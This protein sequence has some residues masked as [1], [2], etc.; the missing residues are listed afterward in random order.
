MVEKYF[1]EIGKIE[2]EKRDARIT[3]DQGKLIEELKDAEFPRD[4][5]LNA[6]NTVASKYFRRKD[7]PNIEKETKLEQLTGRVSNKITQWGYEQGHLDKNSLDDFANEIKALTTRQYGSFN[8][9]VWFNLGLDSY[10]LKQFGEETFYVENGKVKATD[11][12]HEHPQSAACFILSPEDSIKDMIHVGAT[13]SA[14]I[15]KGGSGIGG[16]WS[17][18]RSAGEPVSGGGYASGAIR[19]MD[20]QD[21]SGRVIKSGGKTRRAATMQSIGVW[22][23]DV[24]EVLKHKYKEEQ[25]AKILIESGSPS[26]WESHTIQDLRA[27]NVNISIRIDDEFWKAYENNSNY[28]IKRVK[29]GKIVREVPARDLLEQ[30]AF[31]THQCGDPGIQNHTLINDWNTCKSSGNIWASNPC[32][33][34]M[35]LNGSACNLASHNLMKYR[36]RDG[37]FDLEAFDKATDL[38]ITSQDILVSKSSYPTE[39]IAWNSHIFRPLGL[40]YANLGAY[41]MSLGIP[42]DSE[43]GR[44]FAAAITANMTAE[45]YLQSTKLAEQLGPFQ[46]FSKNKE[47]MMEVISMHQKATKKMPSVNGLEELVM[48][49]NKKWEEVIDRGNKYGFRNAQVTL[50]APTG[51][52]GFMMD[53]DTTGCEPVYATKASKEL[54]GG[55]YMKIVNKTIPLALEKL[56][57]TPE[58]IDKIIKYVEINE[59]VEGAPELKEEHLP[60]FDCA[61]SSGNGT[62]FIQPI[63]H[64]KML[65]AIQP[66]LSGAI[67][68]TINCP[69]STS[70]EEIMEM[71][72][73]SRKYGVKAAAIYRDGSKA[74]QPLTSKK[75]KNIEILLGRGKREPL[76][77]LRKGITQKA[78]VGGT[79]LFLRTGEYDSGRLGEL[80]IES[81]ER[82]SEVNRLL[83]ELAIQFSEKLQYGVPLNEALEIFSKAG[84]SQISG[85][86]N[87]P[88]IK[89]ARGIEGFIYDWI[90]AHYLGNI[91]SVSKNDP[92]LRPF[93]WELRVYQQV[94]KLHL[95]PSV[96]GM[97]F[98][99]GAPTLEE[100]IK[101]ISGTNYW[102]DKE[103]KLDT[104]KTIEKIKK[105]RK[106]KSENIQEEI[107][108]GRM[109]GKTCNVCGSILIT[110]GTCSK[111]PV[112]KISSGGCGA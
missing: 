73:Q 30:I 111:C 60:V 32:S 109:T 101:K 40:G 53:C 28:K 70:V 69:N 54:A 6:S 83:N 29:D 26:N 65:G 23:P 36:K 24:P 11:N 48:S 71:F 91:S 77:E 67:S 90:N 1:S 51:T 15:F 12:Y 9:P 46:E 21:T 92:E 50:L 75:G 80:F 57:Y 68:K 35:F 61:V 45:A 97:G 110:D 105:T 79:S 10:G 19:F 99:E 2:Y 38:F 27:Q 34:F 3:D 7:I 76:P 72:Y 55:G 14:R 94:P 96:A 16:D 78:K 107:L 87:H 86:T 62:R 82:G 18:V 25:K 43:E 22:H 112:C 58:Q 52:I 95:I 74:S 103:E 81:L 4:W 41:L 56:N 31:A 44:N 84:Q 33:E 63:A 98:Y 108:S 102:M 37:S 49:A 85:F 93:P 100:T 59:T 5:S 66:Y 39:E 106:W 8:S 47:P 13:V 17:A 20:V 89:S 42:Y 104:R 64:I 88:F